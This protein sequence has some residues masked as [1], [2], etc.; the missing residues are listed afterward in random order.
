MTE[1]TFTIENYLSQIINDIDDKKIQGIAKKAIDE[2]FNKLTDKQ[3]YAL[4]N[5]EY[6]VEKCPNCGDTIEYEDMQFTIINGK[7][8]SCQRDWD[9]N[10]DND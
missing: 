1:N 5:S 3:Q 2:G 9:K 8:P 7:C 10:Y 4:K 6:F